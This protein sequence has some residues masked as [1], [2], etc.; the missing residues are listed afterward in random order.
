MSCELCET[1]GG[2]LIW[3]DAKC[4]VVRVADPDYPGFCRVIWRE[5][6]REMTDLSPPD[7]AHL[8]QR[9]FV[10]ETALRSLMKPDKIN[11]ASLG[12]LTPHLHWHVIPRFVGD[13]HFPRPVWAE[14]AAREHVVARFEEAHI[15]ERV[16]EALNGNDGSELD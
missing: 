8:M 3:Q 16:R 12:N 4:R 2:D 13:R 1:A 15:V 7:R 5:H 10:V 14:A 11:L 9:V 6:I